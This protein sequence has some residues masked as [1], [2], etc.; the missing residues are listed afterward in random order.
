MLC[1]GGVFGAWD[2]RRGRHSCGEFTDEG[3]RRIVSQ[4]RMG[5]DGIAI[6][7]PF[8]NNRLSMSQ[9]SQDSFVEQFITHT[10]VEALDKTVLHEFTSAM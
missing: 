3:F 1:K 6:R 9:T 10:P 4:S 2:R 8:T 5:S 7:H